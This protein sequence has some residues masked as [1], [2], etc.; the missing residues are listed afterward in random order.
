M[1]N[2]NYAIVNIIGEMDNIDFGLDPLPNLR[3]L[4]I[5]GGVNGSSIY[6]SLLGDIAKLRLERLD[7]DNVLDEADLDALCEILTTLP[8]L[9]LF[10]VGF[11]SMKLIKVIQSSEKL[12]HAMGNITHFVVK[13][14]SALNAVDTIEILSLLENLKQITVC[15]RPIEFDTDKRTIARHTAAAHAKAREPR[16]ARVSIQPYRLR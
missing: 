12:R 4:K 7:L 10:S 5:N 9:W 14:I 11:H 3:S 2:I 1:P 15:L 13:S 6:L 8:R 16:S